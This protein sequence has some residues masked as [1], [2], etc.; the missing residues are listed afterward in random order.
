MAAQQMLRHGPH[1]CCLQ[2]LHSIGITHRDL[3][4]ENL[5]YASSD[6]SSP[7][8]NTIKVVH[9]AYIFHSAEDIRSATLLIESYSLL[10]SVP[11][12]TNRK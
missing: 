1:M 8:Y 10:L 3:K 2:Y 6:P 12:K 5:L 7:D 4:P 11:G 9:I